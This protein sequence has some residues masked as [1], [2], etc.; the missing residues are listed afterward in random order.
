[1][2]TVFAITGKDYVLIAADKAAVNQII[3]LHDSEDKLVKVGSHQVLSTV[4]EVSDRKD[5]AGLVKAETNYYYYRYNQR[6][7]TKELASFTRNLVA[8]SL[9]T[10]NRYMV[11]SMVAGFDKE[12]SLFLIENLGAMERVTKC[13]MGYCSY[14]LY[15][16]MDTYYSKDFSLKEG[17]DCIKSCI[18]E[19]KTRFL[20]N[21]TEYD[22]WLVNKDGV[23]D[24]SYEFNLDDIVEN[25]RARNPVNNDV[26]MDNQGNIEQFGSVV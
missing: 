21:I 2:D 10:R 6:L 9:R 20:I 13:A 17:K 25:R 19:L 24:I 14:F 23:S 3:K 12:P 5:F 4:G 22:V 1:M 15:G 7:E 18:Y 26:E 16:L 8:E 11:S